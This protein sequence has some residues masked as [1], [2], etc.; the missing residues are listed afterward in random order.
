VIAGILIGLAA[1]SRLHSV[2][3]SLPA[4]VILLWL[5]KPFAKPDYPAWVLKWSKRVLPA[6]WAAAGLGIIRAQVG[7]Q[8]VPSARRFVIAAAVAWMATSGAAVFLYR[9]GRTRPL[10]VRLLSPDIIKLGLGCGIGGILGNPTILWQYNYFL[11][12]VQMYSGYVDQE[13]LDWPFWK[14]A[15]WYFRHYITVAAPDKVT[16]VLLCLGTIAILI[17]RDRKVIPF[18]AGAALF[19]FSKPIWLRASFHHLILWLPFFYIVCSYPVGKAFDW[20]CRRFRHGEWVAAAALGLGLFL[21]FQS[22]TPGPRNATA[23]MEGSE[24]R[25]QS[26]QSAT[27]WL[28]DNAEPKAFVAISYFCFNPDTFYSWLASLEVPVPAGVFDGREY[29]IWWGHARA[30]QGRTGYACVT[31]SDLE[32]IKYRL[33]IAEP[34]QGTDP[35]ADTRFRRVMSF[36]SG[37]SEVDLFRFD[38]R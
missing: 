30:L 31:P 6:T 37:P 33:N 14:N 15:T 23:D 29:L 28:H 25:M 32:A 21:C 8:A 35:Y 4:L 27:N 16:L 10:I 12:S 22:L 19:F 11:G 3:A 5:Q 17:A 34:G 26:I 36:G 9:N 24:K 7:L 13:R 18:L 20:L 38:Y 1:G 2:T